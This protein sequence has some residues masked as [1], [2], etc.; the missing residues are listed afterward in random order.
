MASKENVAL[1]IMSEASIG[2][3]EEQ[4]AVGFAC[5]RNSK[6]AKNQTPTKAILDLAEKI[7][8][9]TISDPTKGANHWYSPRS[10]PKE[11]QET[12]GYD[13]KGGLEQVEGVSKKNYK[14]GWA[15]S[16]KEVHIAG[17]RPAYFKFF[18]I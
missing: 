14:P 18:K 4:I 5:Q 9:G 2:N 10:M 3:K 13:V 17:V 11:G 16:K 1:A 7:V 6:H 15:D 12:K 8:N